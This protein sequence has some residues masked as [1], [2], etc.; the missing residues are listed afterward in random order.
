[1]ASRAAL[2]VRAKDAGAWAR[3]RY[4]AFRDQSPYFQAKVGLA[5]AY[6]VVVL[7]TV[8][9]APPRGAVWQ[10][11]QQRINFGL[12]FKTAITI[13]NLRAGDLEDVVVEVKGTGIEFDGKKDPG[14]WRTKPLDMPEGKELQI[15]TE[16]LFDDRGVNPPY[17]LVV[18]TVRVVDDDKETV[19]VLHPKQ[20]GGA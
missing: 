20:V 10:A 2:T 7:L 15:L 4:Q 9:V 14:T 19:V 18:D 1:M 3:G 16:Q 6:V 5:A 12:A 17:S 11:S 13:T 8:L